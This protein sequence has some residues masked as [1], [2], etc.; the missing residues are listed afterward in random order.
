MCL[1]LIKVS[2]YR[3]HYHLHI[4]SSYY[5]KHEHLL[6]QNI[7]G[8]NDISGKT[9]LSIFDL[10]LWL[11]GQID[12][13]T[14]SA[15]CMVEPAKWCSMRQPFPWILHQGD[16]ALKWHTKLIAISASGDGDAVGESFNSSLSFETAIEISLSNDYCTSTHFS[17]ERWPAFLKSLYL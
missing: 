8:V 1:D 17:A 5:A 2:D 15:T 16:T 3:L 7:R 6:S 10:D 12:N 4:M 13:S 9:D 11:Q 14:K